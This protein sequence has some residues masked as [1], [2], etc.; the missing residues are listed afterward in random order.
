MSDQYH[1]ECFCGAVQRWVLAVL[2]EAPPYKERRHLFTL[3]NE[4]T[5]YKHCTI[6]Q[7]RKTSAEI[8][9]QPHPH[10][11]SGRAKHSSGQV[12][13]ASQNR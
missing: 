4:K 1:G 8:M 9:V 5:Q 2:V 6:L 12:S 7:T 3:R 11:P 10:P 13:S